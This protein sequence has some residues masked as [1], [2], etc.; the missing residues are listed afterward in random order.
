MTWVRIPLS[1]AENSR[2]PKNKLEG[3]IRFIFNFNFCV[4]M[5]VARFFSGVGGRQFY[6]KYFLDVNQASTQIFQKRGGVSLS[7]N[8]RHSRGQPY[9]I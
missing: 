1:P 3:H 2:G 7:D 4:S 9:V 5:G 8:F 6:C